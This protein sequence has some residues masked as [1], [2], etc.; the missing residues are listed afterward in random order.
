MNK[1]IVKKAV[2][3]A[4]KELEEKQ[5]ERVKD[6]VRRTLERIK[7]IQEQIDLLEDEK[8]IL[9]LDIED[10]KEGRLDRIEQRQK[11]DEKAKKASIVEVVKEVHHHHY[12]WWHTPYRIIYHEVEIPQ[13]PKLPNVWCKTIGSAGDASLG[14]STS[15]GT[16]FTN[17]TTSFMLD[18]SVAKKNVIGTY[19][20]LD[21]TVH[22]R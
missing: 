8:K 1:E 21:A 17:A 3:S 10:L 19:K 20:V 22:L 14:Y 6:I 15:S 12:D 2:E 5:I 7:L 16:T 11:E 9:K 18:A 4:E 13:Y